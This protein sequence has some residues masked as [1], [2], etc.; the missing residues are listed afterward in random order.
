MLGFKPSISDVGIS[1]NLQTWMLETAIVFAWLVWGL[2]PLHGVTNVHQQ[3]TGL[4]VTTSMSSHQQA[5][6]L[7]EADDDQNNKMCC[8]PRSLNESCFDETDES[9]G[10][11]D[12]LRFG[13]WQKL[14]NRQG[15]DSLQRPSVSFVG[16]DSVN[17][18][19][20]SWRGSCWIEFTFWFE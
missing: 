2:H 10:L 11:G 4:V 5:E 7:A 8:M 6:A 12:A 18:Q 19:L 14:M 13:K 15:R 16:T 3:E 9:S 1:S 20:V 17:H